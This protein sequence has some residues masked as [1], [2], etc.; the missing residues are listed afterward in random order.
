[1]KTIRL[2]T[3]LA[4]CVTALSCGCDKTPA[5]EEVVELQMPGNP[6][7]TELY[8]ADPSAHVWDDGR[9]AAAT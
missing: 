6:F 4:A 3:I 2:L 1:M 9:P 5:A 7:I 8:L